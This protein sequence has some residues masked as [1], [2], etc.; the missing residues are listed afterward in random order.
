MVITN[1]HSLS[2]GHSSPMHTSA[3]VLH[4]QQ[5]KQQRRWHLSHPWHLEGFYSATC[6][7]FLGQPSTLRPAL[8]RFKNYLFGSVRSSLWPSNSLL[9][10]VGSSALTRDWTQRLCTGAW[11]RSHWGS[12]THPFSNSSFFLSL[13]FTLFFSTLLFSLL[14]IHSR[15]STLHFSGAG[16]ASPL[17][18]PG[19]ETSE[20][21]CW[22]IWRVW[23]PR[24]HPRPIK[25]R[26]S[27]GD[28]NISDF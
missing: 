1:M 17:C 26:T 3:S 5:Y 27:V 8:T 13:E 2:I 23:E 25:M 15:R 20:V 7:A 16:N 10:H 12:P 14:F 4:S 22:I 19:F 28:P 6:L 24:P 9:Q 11:S 21:N 18:V